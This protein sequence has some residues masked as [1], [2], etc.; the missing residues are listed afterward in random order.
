M[1][2]PVTLLRA[3]LSGLAKTG[4]DTE[5]E[6]LV[7]DRSRNAGSYWR[8]IYQGSFIGTVNPRDACNVG[9][10][11]VEVRGHCTGYCCRPQSR[12]L[13]YAS[14]RGASWGDV[15]EH[16]L[17]LRVR[18]NRVSSDEVTSVTPTDG[19]EH[20]LGSQGRVVGVSVISLVVIDGD[21]TRLRPGPLRSPFSVSRGKDLHHIQCQRSRS[22]ASGG[23]CHRTS[24]AS[25]RWRRCAPP[26]P[27][28]TRCHGVFA[29]V[30]RPR[31]Q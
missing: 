12:V 22:P 20:A 3:V 24:Q 21:V 2:R 1:P 31:A 25:C 13:P 27:A 26:Q 15:R 19:V 28:R 23:P 17:R 4:P 16:F 7:R 5:V 8:L 10:G 30:K 14:T 11:G 18:S 9:P 6:V 29:L